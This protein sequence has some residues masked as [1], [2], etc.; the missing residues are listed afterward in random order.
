M[1]KTIKSSVDFEIELSEAEYK[2]S[3]GQEPKNELA[4]FMI[5]REILKYSKD[6]L[7]SSL[8]QAKGKHLNIVK[9]RL[10]KV[11]IS[12]KLISVFI[13]SIIGDFLIGEDEV[14]EKQEEDSDFLSSNHMTH[15]EFK[16]ELTK[17]KE[18]E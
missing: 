13:E 11:S 1:V 4:A 18:G 2:I 17:V 15:E 14:K 10:Q 3:Y 7:K 16:E 5:V 6:N 9:D 8:D 12:E